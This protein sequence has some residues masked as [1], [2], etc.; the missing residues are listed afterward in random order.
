RPATAVLVAAAIAGL[1]RWPAAASGDGG[2]GT[3][4][5]PVPGTPGAVSELAARLRARPASEALR[6]LRAASGLLPAFRESRWP[7]RALSL[8]S[9]W[10][11]ERGAGRSHLHGPAARQLLAGRGPRL[12]HRPRVSARRRSSLLRLWRRGSGSAAVHSG[13]RRADA[14]RGRAD[15]AALRA[16]LAAARARAGRGA[17]R[18]RAFR[19]RRTGGATQDRGGPIQC[20]ANS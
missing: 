7:S 18:H 11:G 16:R 4:D 17:G 12:R 19:P 20:L 2:V 5:S 10:R 3:D 8:R 13:L 15:A 6:D 14:F 9:L 1:L